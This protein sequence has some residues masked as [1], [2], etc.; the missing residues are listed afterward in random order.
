MTFGLSREHHLFAGGTRTSNP[1]APLIAGLP[2]SAGHRL[3]VDVD[4]RQDAETAHRGQKEPREREQHAELG[5][6][7]R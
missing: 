1:D 4:R 5:D 6:D 3:A 7:E 2:R